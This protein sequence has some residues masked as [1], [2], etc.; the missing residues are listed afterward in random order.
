MVV[1]IDANI[2]ISASLNLKGKIANIIFTNSAK[3][4]FVVPTFILAELKE[5]EV[6]ICKESKLTTNEFNKNLLLLLSKIMVINDDEISN[7]LFK[8][9][10]EL[11][12]LIDPKDTIYIAMAIALNALVWTGDL[13]LLKALKRK[14]YNHIITTAD[15]QQI[16]KGI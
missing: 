5:N 1:V 2:L 14:G 15:F 9:A 11:T 3:A 8:K 13:K 6:K 10:F 16:L 12:K 4:N 7:S